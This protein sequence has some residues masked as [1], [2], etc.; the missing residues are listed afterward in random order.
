VCRKIAHRH[1]GSIVAK[2]EKGQGATFIIRLPVK[3]ITKS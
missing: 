1:G 3:Q 2:S